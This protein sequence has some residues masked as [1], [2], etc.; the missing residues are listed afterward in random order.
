MNIPPDQ[1]HIPKGFNFPFRSLH[2]VYPLAAFV[3][4]LWRLR[5][6]E[7]LIT[8]NIEK[9]RK[10]FIWGVDVWSMGLEYMTSVCLVTLL[11]ARLPLASPRTSIFVHSN[12]VD[13]FFVERCAWITNPILKCHHKTWINR[14]FYISPSFEWW[15]L[16]IR[17]VTVFTKSWHHFIGWFLLLLYC[18]HVDND[19]RFPSSC[20]YHS[21]NGAWGCASW[22]CAHILLA[23]FVRFLRHPAPQTGWWFAWQHFHV[24]DIVGVY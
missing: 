21:M 11:F 18:H 4:V 1:K 24:A 3:M 5:G 13:A 7:K 23:L 6:V 10:L 2:N 16:I 14:Y 19:Y 9:G 20:Y 15:W 12:V 22:L 17:R 8:N